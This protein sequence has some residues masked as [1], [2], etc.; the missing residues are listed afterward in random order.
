MRGESFPDPRRP[1]LLA[2]RRGVPWNSGL[3]F[4]RTTLG[5]CAVIRNSDVVVVYG[6][7]DTVFINSTGVE[8]TQKSDE[9]SGN[10]VRTKKKLNGHYFAPASAIRLEAREPAL[11][12]KPTYRTALGAAYVADSREFLRALPDQSVNLVLTSPPYALHFKKEYGN[13]EKHGYVAWFLPFAR[14]IFRVLRS[15][16]SFILNIGGSFNPSAPTRS[17]YHFK[18]LIALVEEIGFHL[19][20]ECF[21]Y[22]PAK[23][24]APAEWVTVRRQ[25]VKDS[26][27]YVWWLSKTAWPKANNRNVLVPYSA[28]MQRLIKKGYRAKLRPSGHNIT[29][30]FQADRGGAIPSNIIERGNNESN[31]EYIKAC[32]AANLKVHPARFP[33]ALPEFFI[34]L[35]TRPGDTVVDP[36]AGSNTTGYVA[37]MLGRPWIAI[38]MNADYVSASKLRFT[39]RGAGRDRKRTDSDSQP[40]LPFDSVA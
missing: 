18:L 35:C 34:K 30:K 4:R 15:D 11:P 16:G 36:F 19:A 32:R 10:V 1:S 40:S 26:V 9:G 2:G 29:H 21:W 39:A 3:A 28:D 38:E 37:E 14:E 22:N 7:E 23:L 25:R 13:V 27:E 24:P 6:L 5:A 31:S 33:A 17:L 8:C 12:D 20:Q